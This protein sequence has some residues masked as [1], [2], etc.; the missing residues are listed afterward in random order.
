MNSEFYLIL[1]VYFLIPTNIHEPFISSDD[2]ESDECILMAGN[3]NPNNRVRLCVEPHAELEPYIGETHTSTASSGH[4]I[5]D[6]CHSLQMG[7]FLNTEGTAIC[8]A[9]HAT[10]LMGI[11]QVA[12]GHPDGNVGALGHNNHTSRIVQNLGALF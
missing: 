10:A 8:S 6:T 5:S 9:T 7:G 1:H 2:E 4:N 3:S 11:L 12:R